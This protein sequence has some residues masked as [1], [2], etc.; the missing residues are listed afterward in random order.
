MAVNYFGKRRLEKIFFHYISDRKD[1]TKIV[2]K[3]LK[4]S[5]KDFVFHYRKHR[6]FEWFKV[7]VFNEKNKELFDYELFTH[8]SDKGSRISMT[9]LRMKYADNDSECESPT[10][11]EKLYLYAYYTE[12]FYPYAGEPKLRCREVCKTSLTGETA[13]VYQTE[14]GEHFSLEPTD[15]NGR[16]ISASEHKGNVYKCTLPPMF[17]IG[18]S[19]ERKWLFMKDVDVDVHICKNKNGMPCIKFMN[20]NHCDY[21]EFLQIEKE[22]LP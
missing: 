4:K 5:G 6:G 20:R 12:D 8:T 16:Y 2:K 7:S 22:G 14:D 18:F 9:E 3:N 10:T 19:G 17:Y 1:L 21:D 11:K 13:T 15:N